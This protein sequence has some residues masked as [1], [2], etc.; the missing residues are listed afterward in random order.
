MYVSN[1]VDLIFEIKV[2]ILLSLFFKQETYQLVGQEK[3][4]NTKL[5][6]KAV[7]SGIFDCFSNFDK[8]RPEVAGDIISDVAVDYVHMD[9]HATFGGSKLNS[10]RII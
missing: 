8:C 2:R 1:T 3:R 4:R 6:L 5:R 10:G 9:I 7:G